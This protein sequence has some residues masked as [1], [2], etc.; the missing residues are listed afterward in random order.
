MNKI[1][2]KLLLVFVFILIP[3]MSY[4]ID[5][6][7]VNAKAG[8]ALVAYAIGLIIGVLAGIVATELKYAYKR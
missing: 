7:Q 2:W 3:L 6:W 4:E 8:F 1:I 5:V